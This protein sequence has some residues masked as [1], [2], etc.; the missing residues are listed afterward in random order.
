MSETALRNVLF[1]LAAIHLGLGA[2][3]AIDP[4]T[5]F[6]EVG[7]YG[8]RN[9]H[10]IG[11]GSA[12]YLAVGIGL[13]LAAG[14]PSWR[15]PVLAVAAIWY[16]LHALNHLVDIDEARTDSR[17]IFDTAALALG[18]LGLAWLAQLSST[19]RSG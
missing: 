3:M 4:G 8:V 19:D 1:V 16:G 5:F 15:V 7:R 14:R 12:F 11:D 13:V 6:E 18:A 17:G 2:L 9:D 10:Y